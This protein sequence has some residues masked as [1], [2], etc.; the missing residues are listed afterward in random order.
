MGFD[1]I[2][3]A[4][5][6]TQ[7][8]LK[9]AVEGKLT[10]VLFI[11]CLASSIV[12]TFVETGVVNPFA[13]ELW[14]GLANRF[15]TTYVTF[16]LFIG[17]GEND[18]LLRTPRHNAIA[19]ELE[20]ISRAIYAG[21]LL[22]PFYEFCAVKEKKN[23]EKKRRAIYERY[24]TT[25]VYDECTRLTKRELA[26]MKKNGKLTKEQ[27][28]AVKKAL[29]VKARP[30]KPAYILSSCLFDKTEE[31]GTAVMSYAKKSILTRPVS[32]VVMSIILNSVTMTW[33]ST[34]PA[35]AIVGVVTSGVIIFYS[36]LSGYKVGKNS[37]IWET[38]Q[39]SHRIRFLKEFDEWR[40]AQKSSE[41]LPNC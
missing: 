40:S 12:L 22:T 34:S 11:L 2:I 18:E 9:G 35:E 13:P 31:A 29:A 39:K 24:V 23:A 15:I 28:D 6:G 25:E 38:S 30:I 4:G 32:F 7:K 19:E 37:A 33:T 3:Q 27:H 1:D 20:N 26:E 41:M 21:G 14:V 36:A 10:S 16:I 5:E 8:R 17:P